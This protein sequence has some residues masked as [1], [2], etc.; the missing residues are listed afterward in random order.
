MKEHL[1]K[2]MNA[3]LPA[4]MLWAPVLASS[5]RS[6]SRFQTKSAA[7]KTVIETPALV[8]T[9]GQQAASRKADPFA[10][11]G[12][13]TRVSGPA[14]PAGNN[15]E[16]ILQ[17]LHEQNLLSESCEKPSLVSGDSIMGRKD[18]AAGV[19]QNSSGF[20][21]PTYTKQTSCE[22]CTWTTLTWVVGPP[23]VQNASVSDINSTSFKLNATTNA[24]CTLYAVA[25]LRT[26]SA[27]SSAQVKDGKDGTGASAAAS[28]SSSSA[29]SHQITLN[30][31]N[32]D[33]NLYNVYFAAED[34]DG[35]MATP[36]MHNVLTRTTYTQQTLIDYGTNR[37]GN[38]DIEIDSSN[39][40][41]IFYQYDTDSCR[42]SKWNGSSFST[43][44]DLAKGAVNSMSA[45]MGD[46]V[47]D[48]SGN[49]HVLINR[50]TDINASSGDMYHNK[51]SG[52]WSGFTKVYDGSTAPD[53]NLAS[54]DF[55]FADSSNK[56]HLTF[57]VNS[58]AYYATNASGSWA[59]AYLE[60]SKNGDKRWTIVESGGTAHAFYMAD[61]GQDLKTASS[62]DSFSAK[63]ARVDTSNGLSVGNVIVDSSDKL[64][65]V[66][67]DT[68]N[69]TAFY[70]TNASGSW[71]TE[72]LTSP[73][74]TNI[75]AKYILLNGS[76][77]YVMMYNVT[78]K[79]FY[80][81]LKSSGTWTDGYFFDA[82]GANSFIIDPVNSK[83]F[84]PF[85]SSSAL[86]YIYYYVDD[87]SSFVAGGASN[88]TPVISIDNTNLAYTEND[89]ATQIDGAAT[90]SDADGDSDWD[91]GTLEVQISSNSESADELSI[92]D[93][94]VGTVNT[95]G[96]SLKNGS[97]VIGT[98]SASEG[99][100]TNSTTLTVTFN[101]NAT[102]AL[103]QQAVR[104]IHYRNTSDN[105]GT[106]DRTVTFTL[107]DKNAASANDTRT[108]PISAQNDAPTDISLSGTSVN[109]NQPSGTSV[110]TIST[111]DPDN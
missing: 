64:H 90:A 56:I 23:S 1:K 3:V 89:A 25:V 46:M 24:T 67:S 43:Y 82:A 47:I 15:D 59:T 76:D 30:V 14:T 55:A 85:Q 109:E 108:I 28:G 84:L 102:N 104:A 57:E 44:A 17:F 92:P 80:F 10:V 63:T 86:Q 12:A 52:S 61:N 54:P 18:F 7:V 70:K 81:K 98:L 38:P 27:P 35:L 50:S 62:S 69:G 21:Y 95:G 87:I 60:G 48:G 66:Y 71:V 41:Y 22:S 11:F 94:V 37:W 77:I 65:I 97:T 4:L 36:E 42:I 26:G 99:T 110:G 32:A 79:V 53:S 16:Q 93:N 103:V 49:I 5:A 74:F 72:A 39:N 58:E 107:T 100:V 91:G 8:E 51:Y 6:F 33:Q 34:S 2:C 88:Q 73:G 45:E 13:A 105:P 29:S 68:T 96:T 75:Q 19:C 106:S 31:S 40:I 20:S 101:A 9:A 83:I 78:E 111:T